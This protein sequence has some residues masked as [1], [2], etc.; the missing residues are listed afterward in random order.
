MTEPQSPQ[1][2]PQWTEPQPPPQPPSQ[3]TSPPPAPQSGWGAGGPARPERPTGVTLAAIYLIVMGVLLALGGAACGVFGGALTTVDPGTSG[4]D[5]N[6]FAIG[7]AA[8]ALMGI[9]VLVLGVLSIAAGAGALGGKGWARW[10]GIVV[11]GLFVVLGLVAIVS[12]L[13]NLNEQGVATG[14]VF[15]AVITALYG[16]TAY[17][18][19]RAKA[20]F[21]ARR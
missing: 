14:L 4:V 1:P 20:Y 21:A 5:G 7:G 2:Q 16:L 13:G 10:T 8:L 19:I 17:A 3:W 18:L 6:L 9:I 11:S 15:W 12:S